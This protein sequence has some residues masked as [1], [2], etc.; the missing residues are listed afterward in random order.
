M[1]LPVFLGEQKKKRLFFLILR[2]KTISLVSTFLN[3]LIQR[4]RG[5]YHLPV[6]KSCM[7][8]KK[9]LGLAWLQ[10]HEYMITSSIVPI[11]SLLIQDNR[12]YNY[13][14]SSP[15]PAVKNSY[16]TYLPPKYINFG[17]IINNSH[18]KN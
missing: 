8:L 5:K 9:P 11:P 17:V 7:C 13:R 14:Y 18:N 6:V 15:I 12:F 10:L 1:S 2:R 4:I 16:R 3:A